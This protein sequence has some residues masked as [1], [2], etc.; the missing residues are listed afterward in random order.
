[1]A[2]TGDIVTT[3]RGV[4]GRVVAV[5]VQPDPRDHDWPREAA[6]IETDTARE[7]FWADELC[8]LDY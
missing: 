7:W 1:M 3:W 4:V 6:M 2:C 5:E 8:V